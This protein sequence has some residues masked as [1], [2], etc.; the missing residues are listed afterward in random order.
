MPKK[1][2]T[3]AAVERLRSPE[4]GQIEY[5]DTHLPAFGLRISYSGTKA[6]FVMT[7]VD[8]KLIRVTLGRYPTL[9]LAEARD[10]ARQ[11]IEQ[12]KAGNDPREVHAEARRQKEQERRTTFGGIAELF[13][14]RHVVRNLRPNTAREYRRILQGPDTQDWQP[15]PIS[16]ITKADVVDLLHRIEARGS[17]AAA[18]RALAY[19]SKFFNWCLEQDHLTASP[20]IRVRALT[21]TRSRERVLSPEELAWIWKGLD[22]WT[23]TFAALFT[24]LLLTGQRRAEVGGMRWHELR[25]VGTGRAVWEL[26][27]SR[28]KNRQAHLV[29][30]A[31]EVQV[32]L[33]GL[34]QTG[35]LVFTSRSS[36][37]ISGFSKA[38][39]TLDERITALRRQAGLAPLPAWTLHDLRQTMVTM[40]NERLG[41][42]PHIVEAVV[43]HTS[44]PSK[45]GVAGVYN[46]AIYLDERRRALEAWAK[47]VIGRSNDGE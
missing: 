6:W 42:A 27:A 26:P 21:S 47:Y 35:P 30:L 19:L 20:T 12:A 15:R 7:R 45:R 24:I 29:P 2:L 40:M 10:A 28:T 5:F 8:G 13:I 9:S 34:S 44:G 38:K 32:I 23:S 4:A 31:P 22:G 1:H 36:T 18:N 39:A 11:A 17:P 37:S 14:Q 16:S 25:D 41:I 33:A 43:N 3:A 46:R